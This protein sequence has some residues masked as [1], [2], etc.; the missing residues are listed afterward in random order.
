MMTLARGL[1]QPMTRG[2]GGGCPML[3]APLMARTR[4]RWTQRHSWTAAALSL[5]LVTT[6]IVL[7][8]AGNPDPVTVASSADGLTE[9]AP[10]SLPENPQVLIFGDSWTYG[11]AANEPTLGYAYVV[12][13]VAG[14]NTTVNGVRGSGYLR[15]GIDGPD[16][17][18]RMSD[19]GGPSPDLVIVQGS[20]ND[21][22]LPAVGYPAAVNAAW[23]ALSD[24][25]PDAQIVILG[26]AP[27]I[28]PLEPGTARID[29]DLRTLAAARGWWYISPIEEGWITDENFLDVIDTGEGAHHPHTAGH[30]YLAERLAESI[31]AISR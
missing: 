9:P 13:G 3:Y 23:D 28:L 24:R 5:V 29:G 27:Q 19:L 10:I 20:I 17:G 25:Y 12:A 26:P 16:Y 31:A 1:S 6:G 22:R 11:S 7:T 21:R 14:W 15:V 2:F 30:Q 18:T 8:R 4:R